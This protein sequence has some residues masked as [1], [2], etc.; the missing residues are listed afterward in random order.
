M[1]E[2]ENGVFSLSTIDH[3]LT[4]KRSKGKIFDAGVLHHVD[5]LSDHELIYAILDVAYEESKTDKIEEIPMIA[6]PVWR[7]ATSDQ[8]LEF[9]DV[10][11]R[12]LRTLNVDHQVISCTNPHC[13]DP[14]HLEKIDF[15]A[16][17]LLKLIDDAAFKFV[18]VTKLKAKT[19][20]LRPI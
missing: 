17:D 10:V 19:T 3:F 1:F 6:R 2:K 13:V 12:K 18:P 16:S 15:S 4:L 11:F 5:N 7:N 20:R 14:S 9:N 8:K